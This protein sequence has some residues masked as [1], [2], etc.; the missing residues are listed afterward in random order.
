MVDI[1]IIGTGVAGL[2]AAAT[3]VARNKSILLF[4]DEQIGG[5]LNSAHEIK[6]FLGFFGKSEEEIHNELKNHMD[7]LG[8]SVT[9]KK[10]TNIYKMGDHFSLISGRDIFEAKKVILASGISFGKPLAGEIEFLGRG[11]SYCATCD[12]ML[13]K[14]KTVA[15]I[16]Y[17]QHEEKE[18]EF[19]SE[20]C[21]KVLYFPMY[22]EA[23]G[24]VLSGKANVEVLKGKDFVISGGMKAD[25]LV[26]DGEEVGVACTF[27]LR[28]NIPPAQLI[29]GIEM[30]GN[31]IKTDR[32][33]KT[34]VEGLFA[35]GDITGTP[36]QYAKAA[37]EGNVA[38]LSAC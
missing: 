5:K 37:G 34:S 12:G 21:E 22:K 20:I 17:S 8:I 1:A 7:S 14:G 29:S 19:L 38:A 18:A 2:S 24:E 9:P 28:E 25:K 3:A 31:H 6:N 36:Y 30:D 16:S 10:I 15:V 11:V 26:Y 23:V 4:G 13:Y 27:I 32:Q 35:A 33:M